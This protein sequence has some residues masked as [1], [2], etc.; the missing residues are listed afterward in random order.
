MGY[1]LHKYLTKKV[2]VKTDVTFM[3]GNFR[4]FI[5]L[6][7]TNGYIS[8]NLIASGDVL[9]FSVTIVIRNMVCVLV[10]NAEIS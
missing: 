6:K 10:E 9:V 7:Y 8:M 3:K 2:E 5:R 4:T 1:V